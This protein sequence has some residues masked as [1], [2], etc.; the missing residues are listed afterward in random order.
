MEPLMADV[1]HTRRLPE[2]WIGL[3]Y[4]PPSLSR[5]PLISVLLCFPRGTRTKES[6][7][8]F[9]HSDAIIHAFRTNAFRPAATFLRDSSLQDASVIARTFIIR[10]RGQ[11]LTLRQ[12]GVTSK[13]YAVLAAC[14]LSA[15]HHEFKLGT[16]PHPHPSPTPSGLPCVSPSAAKQRI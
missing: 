13:P 2:T 9:G 3:V 5:R 7:S 12:A 1:D 4:L 6:G 16:T 15:T 11:S 14:V 10:A 8:A